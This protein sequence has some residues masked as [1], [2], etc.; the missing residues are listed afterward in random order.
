MNKILVEIEHLFA[1]YNQ[2]IV[3][4]DMSLKICERD[5]WGITGPNGGG[6]TTLI[7]VILGL[8]KPFSGKIKYADS[9]KNRIGYMPQ[10]NSIDRQFPIVVSEMVASGL[11]ATPKLSPEEKKERIQSVIREMGLEELENRP[12]GQLSGGQLQRALLGRAIIGQAELLILD[13]PNSYLDAGFESHFNRLLSEINRQAAIV[14]I[15]HDTDAIAAMTK[16]TLI[17]N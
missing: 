6:K 13:E 12:I 11:N 16:N 5:F 2:N 4:R 1:G 15:S 8:V 9:L 10:T 14:L 7:K 17:V 3:L